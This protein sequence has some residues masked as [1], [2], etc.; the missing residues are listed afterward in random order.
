MGQLDW[1]D[2]RLLYLR[3]LRTALRDKSIIVPSLLVP[4]LLYPVLLW[5]AVSGIT[6]VHGQEERFE[7]RVAL[8]DT[9]AGQEDLQA[10]LEDT[11]RLEL[12]AVPEDFAA[13]VVAGEIDAVVELVPASAA[14][15]GLGGNFRAVIHYDSARD[16]SRRAEE[17]VAAAIEGVQQERLLA[18]GRVL[19]VDAAAWDQFEIETLNLATGGEVGAFLLGLLVPMLT[20]IMLAIGCL[21]PAIDTLAGERER[22]TWETL[23]TTGASRGSIVVAKY[24]Y[25]ATFGCVA[26]LLNLLAITLSMR[27]ILASAVGDDLGALRF[28]IPLTAVPVVLALAVLLALFVAAGMM[29][30]A[31]FARTFK[32]GQSMVMP[33]YLMCLLPTLLVQSPDLELTPFWALVPVSN[34]TLAFREAL[35]GIF[36]WPLIALVL[37]VELGCISAC[38]ALARWTLGFEE[39]LVG[40][41]GG[42]LGKFLKHKLQWKGNP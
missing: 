29:L 15:A 35:G 23:L 2:I 7:S 39:V 37:L 16:R 33:F 36:Q 17:R 40:E 20:I 6:F 30:L 38:L 34:V 42:G 32:E 27:T 26:G 28:R 5:G 1:Q 4:L 21:N 25:V 22:S 8:V 12:V 10:A 18:A 3:E 31:A 9:T 24:F 13:A 19:E 11:E 14:A 41:T